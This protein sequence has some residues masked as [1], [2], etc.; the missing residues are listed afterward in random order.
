MANDQRRRDEPDPRTQR[1]SLQFSNV[2]TEPMDNP[3]DALPSGPAAAPGDL[4]A[5]TLPL[6]NQPGRGDQPE[7][8]TLSGN[9][10]LDLDSDVETRA[11]APGR[12]GSFATVT[13]ALQ[14]PGA[15]T[16]SDQRDIMGSWGT[17]GSDGK[18]E[19]GKVVFGR[20]LV[21]KQLGRGGMGAV[22]LVTH[23]TLET[24]RA[25]KMIVSNI[26]FNPEARGRFKR[27]AQVM[28]RFTHPNAVTVH[29]ALLTND[30]AFIEME[31]V[32]GESLDKLFA[33]GQP[34]PLDW[35]GRI[36]HQ[37][38]DVLQVAHEHGIVHRDLKPSNLMLVEG[39]PPGKDL[40]VLD[41]GIAKILGADVPETDVHTMTNA[42][43]GTPPYTSPEQAQG[44]AD[45]RSDIYS[46]GVILYELIT[47][48]RPFSGAVAKQISDTL[49]SAPPPFSKIN[50]NL[51]GVP[52]EL[53]KLVLRCL[54]KDPSQRPQSALELS[55]AYER[56]VPLNLGPELTQTT[57][58][59]PPPPVIWPWVGVGALIAVALIG[60]VLSLVPWKGGGGR[61]VAGGAPEIGGAQ[62][63]NPLPESLAKLYKPVDPKAL[64][65]GG[66]PTEIVSAQEPTALFQLIE[67]GEFT[68]G[69]LPPMPLI[70]RMRGETLA[71]KEAA[72]QAEWPQPT[73]GTK[74]NT[75]YLQ[76]TEVTN[77]QFLRFLNA[78]NRTPHPREWQAAYDALT[79]EFNLS[80]READQHPAVGVDFELASQYAAWA[81]GRLP[82]SAEWEFAARS[83]EKTGRRYVWQGDEAPQLNTDYAHI[84][85][86]DK[87][88]GPTR[89]ATYPGSRDTTDQHI[90]GMTGNVR[91]WTVDDLHG[92]QPVVRGGSW[93]SRG[94]LFS[95]TGFT[96]LDATN[97]L[98]DLGFR[99]ALDPR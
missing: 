14:G 87:Q 73:P 5:P 28:A 70:E 69:G 12:P 72:A 95:T 37:L 97:A 24:D 11:G 71:E 42:F 52:P 27:E 96:V 19:P 75:F 98:P 66:L 22:W 65:P 40:K 76:E 56:I 32:Q 3:T 85:A 94:D 26:A 55:D 39:R 17:V 93:K 84:D 77:G 20:Y 54:S 33:R 61:D 89:A 57:T 82:T 80:T 48:S 8:S 78:T 91:E 15:P 81:G 47:G 18:L 38:C 43:M 86:P 62:P 2:P 51:T 25:L 10:T 50:P 7:R 30:I 59:P 53:E 67:G 79:N 35:V 4:G 44:T 1:T 45:P 74:V 99:I 83:R 90:V 64:A 58:L 13:E 34:S 49:H 63:V 36:L 23:L 29:D 68:M 46:A 21:K 88:G 41:F 92:G 16:P 9:P 60:G 31:Y 6:E